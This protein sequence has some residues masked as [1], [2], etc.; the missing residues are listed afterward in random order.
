V[1]DL[2]IY[3]VDWDSTARRQSVT[4]NDGSGP[5]QVSITTDFSQGAWLHFP[6]SVAAGGSVTVTVDRTGGANAVLS[7]LFLGG[8]ATG[9]I[10][11]RQVTAAGAVLLEATQPPRNARSL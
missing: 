10:V 11:D 3:A 1:D 2:H 4:V 6:I 5:Q 8:T 9:L 7:G